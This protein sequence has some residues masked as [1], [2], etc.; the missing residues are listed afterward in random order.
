MSDPLASSDISPPKAK[1]LL[2]DDQHANLM[3]L[4]A[5]LEPLGQNVVE[6]TSGHEALWRLADDNFAVVLLDV[7]MEGLDGFETARLIRGGETYRRTPIIFVSAYEDNRLPVAEAY[8]LGAVDYLIKPLVPVIVRAKVAGFVE[9]F[10]K[11]EE[12]KWQAE[13]LRQLERH[14]LEKQLAEENAHLRESAQFHRAIAELASDFAYAAR[15]S[16]EGAV[17]LESVT[18]GFTKITG[19][20]LTE[21]NALGGWTSILFPEDRAST[22]QA[23]A[24]LASGEDAQTEGRILTKTGDL[25]WISFLGHPVEEQDHG[26]SVRIYGAVHDITGRKRAEEELRKAAERLR[27]LWE[28]ATVLL[29]T[30]DPVAMLRSL[31]AKIGPHFGLDTYINFMVDESGTGLR[32]GSC[33]GLAAE[34]IE[35][36]S[37][38]NVG[39]ASS[40]NLAPRR[41]PIVATH[42]QDSDDPLV[43]LIKKFKIR[44][45]AGNP[46]LAE[47]RL[48]GTLSFASRT[49][50]GFSPD[51]LD[52]LRTISHYVTV[53]YERLRLVQELRDH[54]R[55]KDKFLATLAHE[56]RNPLAPIRNSLQILKLAG[57][58]AATLEQSR[59][60]IERQ[61]HHLVHMVDDLLDVSRVMRGKIE[62]RKERVD[63]AVVIARAVE[64]AQPLLDD[65]AHV[66]TID[67]P[68]DP[69]PLEAD[70]VRLVQ[71]IANLLTN[72]AKYTEPN[73]RVFLNAA[74]QGDQAVV[75]VRDNGI[76]I[77]PEML[78]K[79][80]DL[81]VQA[82]HAATRSQGGLGIGLTLVKNLVE[83]H[84][85]K[86]EAHS[87]GLGHGSEFVIHLPL[88]T[89]QVQPGADANE[90]CGQAVS[91]K[92]PTR[93]VL[94]VDDNVDAA[95]SLAILL[96]L[97]GHKVSVAHDGPAALAMVDKD[98]P[99]MVFLDIGMPG[100]DGNEVARKLRRQPDLERL[101][102]VALTGWG[103]TEDRLRTTAAGFDYHLVKPVEPRALEELLISAVR[104]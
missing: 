38:L 94:I 50:D 11:T 97:K 93:R 1:I 32:L 30:E 85:G 62:L 64:T 69:L 99:E 22:D 45:Y 35:E 78:P 59:Q 8:A 52:F 77:A 100:M 48:L 33:T 80:F 49:R 43:Q 91:R 21:L 95:A 86:V 12:V 79:V 15:L 102:L 19:Y 88:R 53:A 13:R 89:D 71:I 61:V 25:R 16:R 4:R 47:G 75:R 14:G 92:A 76:G 34:E 58:D 81:F 44:A 27:L 67:V 57:A 23:I 3:A 87:P 37:R 5:I 83:M 40:G 51:E 29:T 104:R 65:Q 74:R 73:G 17:L 24:Q 63:L 60:M 103:T 66:L 36:V 26:E 10:Q 9:L 98:R 18:E 96:R 56:L 82:D 101:V 2:V 72:A 6:A 55:R 28:A 46:L 90:V 42:L 20:T 7:Q 70:S 39:Q 31:F 54:D 41:R 68:D 84:S